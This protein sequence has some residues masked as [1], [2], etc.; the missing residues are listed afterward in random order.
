MATEVGKLANI[1]RGIFGARRPQFRLYRL[2][3]PGCYHDF[4]PFLFLLAKLSKLRSGHFQLCPQLIIGLNKL[5]GRLRFSEVDP[6][7]RLRR[8]ENTS[9]A[10]FLETSLDLAH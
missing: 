3:F 4:K 1:N 5:E 10:F 7:L 2:P 9:S 6:N 8:I